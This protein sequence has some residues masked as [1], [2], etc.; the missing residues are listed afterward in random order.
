MSETSKD[1]WE[2]W[3]LRFRIT[4]PMTLLVLMLC[5][6]VLNA[7]A[8][9][10]SA[11]AA[12]WGVGAMGF[13]D[14]HLQRKESRRLEQ[15]REIQHRQEQRDYWLR[16]EFRAA[17]RLRERGERVEPLEGRSRVVASGGPPTAPGGWG[18][19]VRCW[20]GGRAGGDV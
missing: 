7:H 6:A 11:L 5:P 15:R 20:A 10:F 9:P 16:E 12:G 3:R 4:L 1:D 14:S 8:G 18:P 19:G 17:D 13:L 2:G